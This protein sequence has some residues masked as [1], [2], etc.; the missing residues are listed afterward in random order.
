MTKKEKDHVHAI[1]EKAQ[2]RYA[3]RL[4]KMPDYDW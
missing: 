3:K 2:K 1:A 4:K